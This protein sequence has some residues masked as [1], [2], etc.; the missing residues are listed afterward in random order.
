MKDYKKILIKII[1][2]LQQERYKEKNNKSV[3][4]KEYC[5]ICPNK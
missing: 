5:H 3:N 1:D 4:F 2:I